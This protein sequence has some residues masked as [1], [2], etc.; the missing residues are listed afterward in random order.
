MAQLF[1]SP[2]VAQTTAAPASAF[3]HSPTMTELFGDSPFVTDPAPG[4]TGPY[5][6]YAYNKMFFATAATAE[7]VRQMLGG[8]AIEQVYAIT[9]F[10]P[11][12]QNQKNNMVRMPILQADTD[13]AAAGNGDNQGRPVDPLGRLINPGLIADIFN[14]GYML[15]NIEKMISDEVGFDWHYAQPVVAPVVAIA[16]VA[17]T[18]LLSAPIGGIAAQMDGTTWKRLT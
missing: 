13:A 1:N 18:E 9:P 16:P 14:H 8:V 3:P 5:G 6:S 15:V 4:G 10:G 2:G 7:K 17:A 12:K 11:F